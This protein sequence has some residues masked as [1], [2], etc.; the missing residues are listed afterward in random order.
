MAK[1]VKKFNFFSNNKRTINIHIDG[2][3]IVTLVILLL[4]LSQVLPK[5]DI[6]L[7]ITEYLTR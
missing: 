7:V 5:E 6:L 4:V 1:K 2:K 3:L